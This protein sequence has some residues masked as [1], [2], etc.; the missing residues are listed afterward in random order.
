[1]KYILAQKTRILGGGLSIF[2]LSQTSQ[3]FDVYDQ[4]KSSAPKFD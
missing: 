2:E 1:M 4:S 3:T